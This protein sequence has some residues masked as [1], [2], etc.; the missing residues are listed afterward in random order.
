MIYNNC[1]CVTLVMNTNQNRV[2]IP[3]TESVS[4]NGNQFNYTI[5]PVTSQSP[6][7]F[8]PRVIR[9]FDDEHEEPMLYGG[10]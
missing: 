7:L 3:Q 9:E 6:P 10:D 2:S 4:S 8:F 1:A 5:A